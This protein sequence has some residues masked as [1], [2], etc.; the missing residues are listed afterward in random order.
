VSMPFRVTAPP[1][2]TAPPSLPPLLVVADSGATG[3]RSLL[4][5]VRQAVAG[6]ARGV[7]WRDRH[8]PPDE[9]RRTA[10]ELALVL[11]EVGGV[12]VASPGPGS[13]DADGCHLGAADTWSPAAPG[14]QGLVGRSCHSAAELARAAAEGCRWATLSPIFASTSKPG[15]G[16]TLGPASL[17]GAPLPTWALGGVDANNAGDC[18]RAG[19]AGVAVMGAVMGAADPAEAVARIQARL[20]EVER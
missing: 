2:T 20:D 10:A 19:A 14:R 12:L 16:P 5:V 17:V 18:L 4:A 3:G 13:E 11:H 15:Y 8:L 7:W 1:P 9:R 6:G